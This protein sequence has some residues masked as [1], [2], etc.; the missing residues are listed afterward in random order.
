M[1]KGFGW[2]RVSLGN[3]ATLSDEVRYVMT[4]KGI[5]HRRRRVVV[6][7]A[8]HVRG[9]SSVQRRPK[10]HMCE[11][12]LSSK[13][14]L[15][16]CWCFLPKKKTPKKSCSITHTYTQKKR[17]KNE[18]NYSGKREDYADWKR[19]Y[20]GDDVLCLVGVERSYQIGLL[21]F[22]LWLNKCFIFPH[23]WLKQSFGLCW[24][25]CDSL[26]TRSSK[27][28]FVVNKEKGGR[29]RMNDKKDSV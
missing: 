24:K 27:S 5:S 25:K 7:A 10:M 4:L 1:K 17:E 29:K 23:G 8:A 2:L 13:S 11:D 16:C 22:L 3:D 6:L 26:G 21:Q 20:L 28:V 14:A 12:A 18:E 19:S 15:Y 9:R